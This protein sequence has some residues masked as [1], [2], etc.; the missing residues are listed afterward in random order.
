MRNRIYVGILTLGVSCL[1][2]WSARADANP[3]PD[4]PV[5]TAGTPEPER[6]N[7]PWL[8]QPSGK[9]VVAGESRGVPWMSIVLLIG[10]AAAGAF[11]WRHRN[12]FRSYGDRKPNARL[13]VLASVRVGSHA[14][15]V[16]TQVGD[17]N[18]LLGVTDN[19]VRRIAWIDQPAVGQAAPVVEKPR[20]D[21]RPPESRPSQ[22]NFLDAL[23]GARIQANA[24]ARLEARHEARARAESVPPVEASEPRDSVPATEAATPKP[25]AVAAVE[26]PAEAPQVEPEARPQSDARLLAN[27]LDL[28]FPAD[29][30]GPVERIPLE[31]GPPPPAS[32]PP[33]PMPSTSRTASNAALELAQSSTDTVEW[34][35]AAAR[36]KRRSGVPRSS[37][38]VALAEPPKPAADDNTVKAAPMVETPKPANPDNVAK[39]AY[40]EAPKPLIEPLPQPLTL[41]AGPKPIARVEANDQEAL[42]GQAA[43]VLQ[44]KNRRRA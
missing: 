27:Q 43:G 2:V 31:S 32:E 33:A 11:A 23:R 10:I 44:R 37:K 42:E 20:T 13:S 35:R 41:D 34:S 28:G 17:R 21:S 7:R 9:A 12:R 1:T 22:A 18:L 14:Q 16:L 29:T 36:P 25:P 26:K 3:V 30:R 38:S 39:A 40:E 19:S 8:A 6:P 15:L 5:A 24:R 4:V